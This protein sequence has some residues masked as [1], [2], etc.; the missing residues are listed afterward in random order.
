MSLP[1][2]KTEELQCLCE[3]SVILQ[4]REKDRKKKEKKIKFKK[5]AN[6]INEGISIYYAL[7]LNKRIAC[8]EKKKFFF[9]STLWTCEI[10]THFITAKKCICFVSKNM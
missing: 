7:L 3:W 10:S 1:H 6:N 5:K 2:I 9:T 4:P 8:K